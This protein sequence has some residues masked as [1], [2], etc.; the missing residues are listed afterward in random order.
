[1]TTKA[2]G[3]HQPRNQINQEGSLQ[4]TVNVQFF[5]IRKKHTSIEHSKNGHKVM[6]TTSHITMIW[7]F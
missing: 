7:D 6:M 3:V 4:I 5:H 1:M 2:S